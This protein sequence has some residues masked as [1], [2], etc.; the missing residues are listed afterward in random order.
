MKTEKIRQGDIPGVQLRR[1]V[2]VA[3]SSPAELWPFWVETER[4]KRWLCHRARTEDGPPAVFWLE[5][6][7]SRGTVRREY[8]EVFQRA[9]P[10]QLVLGLRQLDAGWKAATMVT[11]ELTGTEAGCE[12]M[13]FQEGFQQLPLSLGLTAWEH[14]RSRWARALERL[15]RVCREPTSR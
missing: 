6:D 7:E 4:Q 8:V 11:V 2:E 3:G 14:S 1:R 12:V 9:E 10:R 13:V 15:A 5:S